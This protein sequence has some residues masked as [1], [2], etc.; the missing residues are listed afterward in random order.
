MAYSADAN[1]AGLDALTSLET[2]DLLIAGDVSDS[3][4]AKKITKA[5]LLTDLGATFEP[6][7]GADDN[8]VTDAE[9][10]VI[11]NTSGTNSGD[12][13]TNSQYSGLA[14]S[15]L[16]LDQTT[17]QTIINGQPVQNTLTASEVVATDANKKLSSLAVATYPSLTELSYVKGVTSAVQTQINAK[18]PSTAPTFAPSVTGSYL[19]ASEA[20]ITDASKNIV[21]APVATYP[22]LTELSYVKG[23]SSA[24]QTQLGAKVAT[25]GNETIA[26][27]KTFSSSPI[28]P[29]PTTDMQ[30]STKKYVDDNAGGTPEGT[31]VKSTGETGGSKY[32]REDGDG[33]CSWQ[34][35]AGAGDMLLGTAQ[36]VTA[37]KT[38]QTGTLKVN[39]DVA[40]SSTAT[41]L[42]VLDGIPATLT[43]T[44]LGYV[45][46]VTSAIQTQLDAKAPL[47]APTFATSVTGSYLTASEVLI[48]DGSKNIVSAPVATYPSLTEL[49]YVKGVTSAVQTQLGTKVDK[50]TYDAHSI[51]YATTDDTPVALTVGEQTV[52]GR[53]TGGN[54]VA[55]AIDSDLAS[56]SANDDTVPSAKATKAMGD[57]KALLAGS[58]SQA[59]S[60]S[61]LE[62]GNASDTTLTRVSA[63]VIAVESVTVPT[64][65]STSTITNKR[66]EPRI[67]TAASY[68]TDTGTSLDVATCDQFQV[69]A[70]AGALKL[71]NPS[72][73]PVAG[74][75]LIVRIKDNGTAR[76][77]TYDTQFRAMG[78]ALPST[79]VISKTVYLGLVYN[80][81]D[82]KWDLVA[83]AQEA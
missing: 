28:V 59:F 30:A 32:L 5:N 47:T 73:T 81:T 10:V 46:G 83:V 55:L 77:L 1:I 78:T 6:L 68:T 7:K 76:A 13:A 43:A 53:A 54:I 26:G 33:T 69:T 19:T 70:Q 62:L 37:A 9:K 34:T 3:N 56:V 27:V 75:K 22:S 17:P 35:P 72:G 51:L 57:L 45:D 65:S 64:I 58:V 20:L 41:E 63:G 24:V 52:V 80:A 8:F 16:S 15:K 2:G 42:N 36:T 12:N 79:T 66:I 4:R 14:A 25:T 11:G 18:A 40:V 49:A 60:V 39:E 44:E 38:F 74:Q 82:T 61:Q 67:V 71:N 31:A 50:A 21:S 23:L 48:T 29:T